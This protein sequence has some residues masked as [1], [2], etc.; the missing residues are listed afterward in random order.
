MDF[1]RV[2][3]SPKAKGVPWTDF[4]EG[5]NE[6]QISAGAKSHFLP[7]NTEFFQKLTFFSKISVRRGGGSCPLL[8]PWVRPWLYVPF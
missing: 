5:Q 1:L 4:K 2:E 3:K 7:K 6:K 8:P